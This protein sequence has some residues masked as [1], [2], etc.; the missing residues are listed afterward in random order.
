MTN[1]FKKLLAPMIV[2]AMLFGG[3][4]L[5][6]AQLDL[7]TGLEEAGDSAGFDTSAGDTQLEQT[8]GTIISVILGFLGVIF[9]VLTI[10]AGFL[11]MTAGGNDSQVDKAKNMLVRAVIGLIIILSAYAITSFVTSNLTTAVA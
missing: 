3:A 8:I 7:S 5:T 10:W 2:G 6:H 4:G 1:T 11:W 9:L